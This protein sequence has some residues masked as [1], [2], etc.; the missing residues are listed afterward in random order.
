MLG[1][2]YF[3]KSSDINLL[4]RING[5]D[6]LLKVFDDKIKTRIMRITLKMIKQKLL[7]IRA[8][9]ARKIGFYLTRRCM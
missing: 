5:S 2:D 8:S 4:I 9:C 6:E 7:P 1:F 3:D